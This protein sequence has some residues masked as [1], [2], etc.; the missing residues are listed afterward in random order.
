MKMRFHALA[1]SVRTRIDHS[2]GIIVTIACMHNLAIRA[3]QP[4]VKS[5]DHTPQHGHPPPCNASNPEPELLPKNQNI[6][7]LGADVENLV[8]WH[9]LH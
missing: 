1:S 9:F 4:D 8:I 2:M 3:K 6:Q 7:S 5:C